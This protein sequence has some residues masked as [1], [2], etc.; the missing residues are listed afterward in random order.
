[1]RRQSLGAVAALLTAVLVLVAAA[2]ATAL[3]AA[4]FQKGIRSSTNAIRVDH[5]KVK[6]GKGSCV[7][8]YAVRQARKMANKEKMFHQD[9]S[10]VLEKC[11]LSMVG[12]NVAYGYTAV[13]ALLKAWMDSPGHR[14][15]ILEPRYR[16][17]GAGARKGE[18]GRWYLAQVFGRK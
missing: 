15:N 5:D 1:M 12:E 14:A 13:G 2:P 4:E 6:L 3:T 8:K 17:L 7:Q 18:D 16:L 11:G 10:V 9:L